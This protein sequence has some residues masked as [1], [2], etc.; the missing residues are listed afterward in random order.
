MFELVKYVSSG[1]FISRG[2]WLHPDK[3]NN[4]YEIIYVTNGEVY[5][6]ENDVE[7]SLKTNDL[8]LLEPN[9]R[10]SGYKASQ[11]VSF[12]WM[13]WQC[14]Y[15]LLPE[16]KIIHLENPYNFSLLLSQLLH[17]SS[18]NALSECLDYITRLILAEIHESAIKANDNRFVDIVA[19]WIR[20]NSDLP[21]RVADVARHFGYNTDYLSRLFKKYYNKNI[22]EYIDETKMEYIKNQLLNT[23]ATLNEIANTC[24]FKEYK[25]FLKFFKYHEKI[26]PTE[27]CNIYS[28]THINNH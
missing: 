23:N 18:S 17:Y 13:H 19:N 16:V 15:N 2:D 9:L 6:N 27:F 8:L 11:N 21:L 28:K 12:Y 24:G 22:K 7:F 1:K 25:Y 26:T 20:N 14:D 10:H 5:I 4:S 3:R